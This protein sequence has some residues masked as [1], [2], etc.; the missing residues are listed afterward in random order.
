LARLKVHLAN[1]LDLCSG[2]ANEC[3]LVATHTIT[4]QKVAMKYISKAVIHMTKTKTRVQREVEYMRTLR[5]PHI[6]KLYVLQTFV[7]V[8]SHDFFIA[9]K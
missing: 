5:H 6:I 7:D 1:L 8:P 9:T 4:G 3:F 2:W